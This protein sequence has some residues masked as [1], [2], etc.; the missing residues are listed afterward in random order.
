[1]KV[2]I[3][4]ILFI[5]ILFSCTTTPSNDNSESV[6]PEFCKAD[7]IEVI[8]LVEKYFTHLKNNEYDEAFRMLYHI[9][10]DKVY[11]LTDKER[12]GV[13]RQY[14]LFPVLDYSI[15]SY[16]F[17]SIH[18]TK[19]NVNVRFS[20]DTINSQL[21]VTIN[22]SVQPQRINAVW[23]LGILNESYMKNINN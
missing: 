23:Y 7:T 6:V 17:N 9:E 18:D 1:M 19:V 21:P 15:K 22:V 12:N 2:I 4:S 14:K 10:N 3:I 13:N 11:N 5:T 20:N 16:E 8:A